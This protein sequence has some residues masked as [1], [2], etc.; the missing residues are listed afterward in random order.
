[1]P[2]TRALTAPMGVVVIGNR[3]TGDVDD[4]AAAP[5]W[6]YPLA[7]GVA[8]PAVGV[9]RLLLPWLPLMLALV[10]ATGLALLL[11]SLAL[12]TA[13]LNLD[14]DTDDGVAAS[15]GAVRVSTRR[16]SLMVH[17]LVQVETQSGANQYVSLL[18][19]RLTPKP[20]SPDSSLLPCSQKHCTDP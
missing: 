20:F 16:F 9:L 12:E 15:D 14:A 5:G 10:L 19:S 17:G 8:A 6:P 2:N 18:F 3:A 13:G 4:A 11:T 1:M 7:V